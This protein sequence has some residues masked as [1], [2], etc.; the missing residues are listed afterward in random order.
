MT[1]PDPGNVEI[2]S[3]AAAQAACVY[4][5]LLVAGEDPGLIFEATL[6]A[7]ERVKSVPDIIWLEDLYKEL[8]QYTNGRA[9][10]L[11]WD[12][13]VAAIPDGWELRESAQLEEVSRVRQRDLEASQ[14]TTARWRARAE[15]AEATIAKVEKALEGVCDSCDYTDLRTA[16]EEE[17]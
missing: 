1:A 13:L 2:H 9:T 8:E 14:A 12:A 11:D 17:S 4:A 6:W 3:R 5:K 16:L 10:E 15:K 7:Y